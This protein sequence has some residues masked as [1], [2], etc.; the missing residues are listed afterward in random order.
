MKIQDLHILNQHK[1]QYN[2]LQKI[3]FLNALQIKDFCKTSR[4]KLKNLKKIKI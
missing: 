3:Y 4:A 1:R 2:E